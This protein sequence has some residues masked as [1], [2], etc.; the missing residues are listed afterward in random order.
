MSFTN[1]VF[2]KR[3]FLLFI[4]FSGQKEVASPVSHFLRVFKGLCLSDRDDSDITQ[5]RIQS[6]VSALRQPQN[7]EMEM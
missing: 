6:Q 1:T 3:Q 7:E 2:T 4:Y 5:V